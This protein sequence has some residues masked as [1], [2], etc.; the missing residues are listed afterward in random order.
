M[1]KRGQ[2][3]IHEEQSHRESQYNIVGYLGEGGPETNQTQGLGGFILC[4]LNF[5]LK[6]YLHQS[7]WHSLTIDKMTY[8]HLDPG[9]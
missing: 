3:Q 2:I 1:L 8:Y 4:Y 5:D 7:Y 6:L 9:E